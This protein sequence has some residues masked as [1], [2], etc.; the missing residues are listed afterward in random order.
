MS[1]Y[2]VRTTSSN[3]YTS[4]GLLSTTGS[5][6]RVGTHGIVLGIGDIIRAGGTCIAAGRMTGTGI[7]ATR[8]II[9]T[10]G[11]LSITDIISTTDTT[12][13]I[14]GFLVENMP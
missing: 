10:T 2:M 5:G 3:R 14:I 12:T 13:C 8:G 9:T 7:T 6:V 1:T 11:A 4:I